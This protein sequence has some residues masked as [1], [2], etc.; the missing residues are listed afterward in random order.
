[1][2]GKLR[3]RELMRK[4][5]AQRGVGKR[6]RKRELRRRRVVER[7]TLPRT[8]FTTV[9]RGNLRKYTRRALCAGLYL[10]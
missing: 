5:V 4:A 10:S 8:R 7:T 3:G 6:V 1:M 2:T 9:V